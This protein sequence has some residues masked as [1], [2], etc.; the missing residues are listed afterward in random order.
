MEA[1]PRSNA[2]DVPGLEITRG[3]KRGQTDCKKN[4]S[5]GRKLQGQAKGQKSQVGE[6]T[7]GDLAEENGG[8]GKGD[9]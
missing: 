8:R 7:E 3:R 1:P 5:S 6:A 4:M 9:G 2:P